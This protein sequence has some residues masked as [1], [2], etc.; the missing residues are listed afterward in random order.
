MLWL[1]VC[2][3]VFTCVYEWEENS[4]LRI[5]VV[6]SSEE[7]V[8]TCLSTEPCLHMRISH[9]KIRVVSFCTFFI[10]IFF[11]LFD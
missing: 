7:H 4:R 9:V 1:Y 8:S 10:F 11:T 3:C 6:V 5:S 2:V